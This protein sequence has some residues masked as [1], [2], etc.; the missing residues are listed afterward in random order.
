MPGTLP[1]HLGAKAPLF[2]EAKPLVKLDRGLVVGQDLEVNAV[3]PELPE[4]VAEERGKGL[5]AQPPAPFS[6]S[7]I[8]MAS[9]A[10][11]FLRSRLRSDTVPVKAPFA[12]NS[13]AKK[14]VFSSERT[15]S[16]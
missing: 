4:G 15:R 11:R 16:S 8:R 14:T 7:P 2:L 6:G 1:P 13:S 12:L 5:P 3:K 9:S 10:F